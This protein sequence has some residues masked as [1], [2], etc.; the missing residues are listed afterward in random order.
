MW[1]L[2]SKV[3]LGGNES[4]RAWPRWGRG[5]GGPRREPSV[6]EVVDRLHLRRR[7]TDR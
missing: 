4:R 5:W 6:P 2:E 1:E 3:A 7:R